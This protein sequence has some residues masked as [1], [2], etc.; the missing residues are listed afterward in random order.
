MK[1]IILL[2]ALMPT[3]TPTA[4]QAD[5]LTCGTRYARAWI[6]N[7]LLSAGV[8]VSCMDELDERQ[9]V[10]C[11]YISQSNEPGLLDLRMRP[12]NNFAADMGVWRLSTTDEGTWTLLGNFH[13]DC[14]SNHGCDVL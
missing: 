11:S 2:A 13:C 7:A 6:V 10:H 8:P 1:L 12:V 9:T 4:A 5:E 14:S 3:L